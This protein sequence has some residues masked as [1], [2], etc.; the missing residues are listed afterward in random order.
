MKQ[1]NELYLVVLS[2]LFAFS[3]LKLTELFQL[4]LQLKVVLD[5]SKAE[6]ISIQAL[7]VF[8]FT[9]GYIL[10]FVLAGLAFYGIIKQL[11]KDNLDETD[12]D[13]GP[14]IASCVIVLIISYS[15]AFGLVLYDLSNKYKHFLEPSRHLMNDNRAP[16]KTMD[17]N[18]VQLRPQNVIP[19]VDANLNM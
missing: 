17:N 3:M 7:S 14:L 15:I 6:D 5:N 11:G 9:A 4:G 19:P 1:K 10:F 12:P 18:A 2:I 8:F 16:M 13:L